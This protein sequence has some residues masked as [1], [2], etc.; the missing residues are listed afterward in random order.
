VTGQPTVAS[1]GA[2]YGPDN[3]QPLNLQVAKVLDIPAGKAANF[4]FFAASPETENAAVLYDVRH[5]ELAERG[6]APA[7]GFEPFHVTATRRAQKVYI[8][9]WSK[10]QGMNGPWAPTINRIERVRQADAMWLI[11]AEDSNVVGGNYRDMVVE[12]SCR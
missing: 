4:T 9:T 1:D 8:S 6:T 7:K 5:R 2:V 12:V 10:P 11:G 3:N